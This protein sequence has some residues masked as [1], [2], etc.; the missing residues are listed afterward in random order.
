MQRKIGWDMQQEMKLERQINDRYSSLEYHARELN[1]YSIKTTLF[2]GEVSIFFFNK[3]TN[4]NNHISFK[5]I[6]K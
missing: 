2:T 1:L 4:I 3:R 5:N 6:L